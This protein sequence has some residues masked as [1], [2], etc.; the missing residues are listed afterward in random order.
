MWTYPKRIR[1]DDDDEGKTISKRDLI[2]AWKAKQKQKPQSKSKAKASKAS[3]TVHSR[4]LLQ[5]CAL[6]VN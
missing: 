6:T 3:A 5:V 2:E 4:L 1:V